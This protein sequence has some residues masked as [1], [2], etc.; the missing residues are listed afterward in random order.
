M[1]GEDDVGI[2]EW[3]VLA[4]FEPRPPCSL[5]RL[6]VPEPHLPP[7]QLS[8]SRSLDGRRRRLLSTPGAS[9]RVG[10]LYSFDFAARR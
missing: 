8:T 7:E 5:Q 3:K 1:I 2:Q 6:S 10:A 4:C 9:C